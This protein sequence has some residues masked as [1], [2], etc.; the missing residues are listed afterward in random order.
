MKNKSKIKKLLKVALIQGQ[1]SIFL[2]P[3]L[4]KLME[5]LEKLIDKGEV[6]DDSGKGEGGTASS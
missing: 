1:Q 3:I 2:T 6:D 4:E 5:D